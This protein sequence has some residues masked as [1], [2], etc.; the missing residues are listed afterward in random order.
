MKNFSSAKGGH[1]GTIAVR[2]A[3]SFAL[4]SFMTFLCVRTRVRITSWLVFD[5]SIIVYRVLSEALF[6][7]LN[8]SKMHEKIT[9]LTLRMKKPRC[10]ETEF[11]VQGHTAGR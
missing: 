11:L 7:T 6:F 5:Q 9:V 3:V 2:L 8:F 10:K 4:L 1:P